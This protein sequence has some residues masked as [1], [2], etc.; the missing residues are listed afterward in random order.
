MAVLQVDNVTKTFSGLTAVDEVSFALDDGEIVGLIGPNGAGKTTTFNLIMGNLRPDQGRIV[1]R[2]RRIDDLPTYKRVQLG[3]GRTY[4]TPKPFHEFTIRE[5]VAACMLPNHV[6]LG[7]Q[8][9]K[10]GERADTVLERV[11]LVDRSGEYPDTLTPAELRR[12][13]IAKALATDPDVVL[14]DEVFAGITRDEAEELADLIQTLRSEGLMFLVVDHVMDVLMPLVDR[15]IVLNFGRKV[16]E[17][18]AD[19]V[20]NDETVRQVY[21]GENTGVT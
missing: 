15:S 19:T 11:G 18:T 1:Y 2:D 8:S 3:L 12:L 5:N 4:Q 9:R 10:F 21:L 20:V 14:L 7:R 13:E 17:G 6:T 16:A